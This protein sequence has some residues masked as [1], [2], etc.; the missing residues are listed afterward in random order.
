MLNKFVK[1]P[2]QLNK[3]VLSNCAICGI[4]QSCAINR[5]ILPK[6]TNKINSFAQ[7]TSDWICQ[8]CYSIWSEPKYW[9]R[10][11][12]A[13]KEKIDFP[14]ITFDPKSSRPTWRELFRSLNPEVERI[15]II[16]TDSKR[17]A[18]QKAR[19]SSGEIFSIFVDDRERGIS[20]N[21][22]CHYQKLVAA[23]DLIEEVYNLGF[24]KNAIEKT[25]L[26]ESKKVFEISLAETI[27]LEKKL[28][29]IRNSPEFI[30]SIIVAQ[31]CS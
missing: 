10:S 17:R 6:H 20:E 9:N 31:K 25:L 23:L 15:I 7:P 19:S 11:L 29:T 18:W 26:K 3:N 12:Y 4:Y 21:F 14:L 16:N 2:T 27:E 1:Y 8:N 22:D 28:N 24:S 13:T 30:P 5:N